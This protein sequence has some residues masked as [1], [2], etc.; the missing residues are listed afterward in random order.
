MEL[1]SEYCHAY[2][3]VGK[4]IA[5]TPVRAIVIGTIILTVAVAAAN[6]AVGAGTPTALDHPTG[7]VA[8]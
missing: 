4:R 6:P 7:A 1:T 5:T 2:T 3:C 8:R